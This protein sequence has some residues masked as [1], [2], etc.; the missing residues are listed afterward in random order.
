[1]QRSGLE[2]L[3]LPAHLGRHQLR[4]VRAQLRLEL[5]LLFGE[6]DVH[7]GGPAGKA[8][9][10]PG[11]EALRANPVAS[12]NFARLRLAARRLRRLATGRPP[13]TSS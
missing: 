2:P 6:V 1:V 11:F 3:D 7:A 5:L 4:E 13:D 10:I 8:R 12:L 9:K